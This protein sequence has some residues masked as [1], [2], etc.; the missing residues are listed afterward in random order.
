MEQARN[1]GQPKD[2]HAKGRGADRARESRP[3]VPKELNRENGASGHG[4]HWPQ[5]GKL[6]QAPRP[7]IYHTV[8]RPGLTPVFGTT[9]PPKGLSGAVRAFAFGYSEDKIRHWGL[10]ML[11]DRI[12][13]VEGW[14]E[15]LAQ[16]RAPMIL[17]RMEFRT[18][19]KLRNPKA[20]PQALG[21]ILAVGA[22]AGIAAFL[23]LR[24]ETRKE[25]SVSAYS[26]PTLTEPDMP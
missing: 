1:M 10:L 12:D 9:C 26:D 5:E 21:A 11:A 19:D 23:L 16:G 2:R 20:R 6:Q 15:D 7:G 24:K 18:L 3:G 22:V 13:M 14:L 8:E 4:A 25:K 17:P